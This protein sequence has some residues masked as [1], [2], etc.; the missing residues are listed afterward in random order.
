MKIQQIILNLHEKQNGTKQNGRQSYII[1]GV[2]AKIIA[3]ILKI[4][5]SHN[6]QELHRKVNN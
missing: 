1:Q 3:P 6:I 5:F 2:Q 4:Q